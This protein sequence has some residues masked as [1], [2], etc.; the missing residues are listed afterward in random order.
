M[1]GF[2]DQCLKVL[3]RQLQAVFCTNQ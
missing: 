1:F 2:N 3:E